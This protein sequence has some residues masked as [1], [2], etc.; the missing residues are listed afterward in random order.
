M[1]S[2]KSDV[3]LYTPFPVL[4]LYSLCTAMNVDEFKVARLELSLL[5]IT[6]SQRM[7]CLL[8]EV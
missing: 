8:V 7:T 3:P 5:V 6:A 2:D 4:P 1:C